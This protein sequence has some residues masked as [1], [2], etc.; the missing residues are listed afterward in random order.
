MLRSWMK[1][2]RPAAAWLAL[3]AALLLPIG[4]IAQDVSLSVTAQPGFFTGKWVYRSYSISANPK[5]TLAKLSLGLNELV[6]AEQTNG[7]ITGQRL[8]QGV[9]YDLAGQAAYAARV[10]ATI[11][12]RGQ[13]TV[14]G[15][16]Y[17]YDYYGYLMPSW[18]VGSVPDTIMGTVLRSDP[19]NPATDPLI[20]SFSATR[21]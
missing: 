9:T 3:V 4:V 21:Q 6:I 1:A 7:A 19:E 14:S 8:G 10:G 15:K 20:A 12:L 13:A 11:R 17:D 18:G 16:L 5:D 2:A